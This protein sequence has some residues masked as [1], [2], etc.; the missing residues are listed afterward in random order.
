MEWKDLLGLVREHLKNMA[1]VG[2]TE[3]QTFVK[4][5]N[6]ARTQ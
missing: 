1:E 2:L 5:T 6:Q 4:N 3:Y